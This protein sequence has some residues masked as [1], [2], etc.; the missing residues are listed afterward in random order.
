M[1]GL[2]IAILCI[3]GFT[4]IRGI[5]T[6]LVQSVSG[7]IGAVAG[8]Y[9]AYFYYP[10]LAGFLE[11]WVEPGSVLNIA[12]FFVIFCAVVIVVTILG[13]VLKWILKIVFLGWVDRLGGGVLGF[14][15]GGIIVS[16]LVIALT[17]F[18]P[19]R[20]TILK[21]SSLL[22]YV[23][24]FSEVMMELVPSDFKGNSF[25]LNMETLKKLRE[26]AEEKIG[27]GK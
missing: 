16:V 10:T 23:S 27:N 19:P 20:S 17:T 3:L 11:K 5:M 1:N 15:K 8:F 24:G 26:K 18:L 14:I 4:L 7:V 21:N 2:D 13:R 25:N 6:G 12:S 22:P 9:A